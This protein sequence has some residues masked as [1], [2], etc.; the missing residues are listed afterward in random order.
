M[1]YNLYGRLGS[2][3]IA[4]L[5]ILSGSFA[6]AQKKGTGS[7]SSGPVFRAAVVK[8]NITPSTPQWLR[9]YN[10]RQSTGVL[11]SIYVKILA[12]DDGKTS[13]F[14]VSTEIVGMPSPEYDRVASIL[15]NRH[16]IDPVNVW[17]SATHTHAAPEIAAHF[18]GIPYPSMVNRS[19]LASQHEID[20]AY[21]ALLSRKIIAGILK[22]RKNL[23]PA[24]LGMGWGFSQANINRRAIDVNGKASLGLNPDGAVD[25]RIGLIRIDK[26]DGK[27]LALIVNYP[28]HGTVMN[29]ENTL[30]SGDAPGIASDY[31]EK[32]TGAPVLY[33]NGAA[34]N[35][36]PI[37]S[38]YPNPKAGHL[39]QFR[40]LLGDRIMEA[41]SKIKSS[42]NAVKLFAGSIVVET[43]RRPDLGWSDDL[44]AYSSTTSTGVNMVRLPVRFLRINDDIAIWSAPVEM[45]CE[46][47]N[48]IRERSPFPF[49]FYF[50]YTNG[51]LGYLPTAA[52]W[53]HEGYEPSVSPF[54]PQVERDLKTAVLGYL[55]GELRSYGH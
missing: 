24:R 9:G 29:G 46:I 34:G 49:T 19:K 17:W 35:L 26:A 41:N 52:A 14:L 38:V 20:T 48:E 39:S 18:K 54:T 5:I 43:P 12:L 16:G 30:I 42:T 1:K 7:T 25:R 2:S 44:A 31:V 4:L 11:D 55:Q 13:F 47:S 36:A 27:P 28:M 6:A 15:K 23:V 53:E 8:T 22:A 40:V 45:F 3:I 21:S 10:P 37:Y 50:G 32:Q 33:F 51:S